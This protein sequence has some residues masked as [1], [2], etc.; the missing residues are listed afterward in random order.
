MAHNGSYYFYFNN[1]GSCPGV[2][3]C[4][5]KAGCAT[6]CF[7][8]FPNYT[9]GKVVGYTHTHTHTHTLHLHPHP[10]Y[11]PPFF[12]SLPSTHP[13]PPHALL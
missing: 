9:K 10:T 5:D 1:W 3:C 6:C 11:F 4:A 12:P 7:N 8:N 2:D 13:R